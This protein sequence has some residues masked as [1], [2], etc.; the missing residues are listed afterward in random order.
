MNSYLCSYYRKIVRWR[1]SSKSS[2]NQSTHRLQIKISVS[3]VSRV[4]SQQTFPISSGSS[5][6]EKSRIQA[7]LTQ[8]LDTCLSKNTTW[9]DTWNFKASTMHHGRETP[10]NTWS[11]KVQQ[12]LAT[13]RKINH[14]PV[15]VIQ[16]KVK[17]KYLYS[18]NNSMIDITD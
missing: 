2:L 18:E 17:P 8:A 7:A 15:Q 6:H 10:I 11:N 9:Y 14:I 16:K 3:H 13:H 1:K 4:T 12:S 5:S